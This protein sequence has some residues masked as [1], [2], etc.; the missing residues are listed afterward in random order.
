M[1]S[2][3]GMDSVERIDSVEERVEFAE[4]VG[5]NVVLL[6]FGTSVL[7]MIVP[8]G[9]VSFLIDSESGFNVTILGFLFSTSCLGFFRRML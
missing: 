7:F 6:I 2:V 5:L 9:F 4:R 8:V 1:D 3:A